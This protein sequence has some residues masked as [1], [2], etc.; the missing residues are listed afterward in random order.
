MSIKTKF[1]IS[2]IIMLVLPVFIMLLI[3][4][5]IF[6]IFASYMPGISIEISGMSET[7][8]N[9]VMQKYAILW[10]IILIGVVAICCV[11][12]TTYLS[13]TILSPLRQ[14]IDAMEHI[15]K[16]DLDYEFTCSADKEIR[17]VYDSLDRLRISLKNSVSSELRR[18]K[19]YRRLI[20]NI[21][22]DLRTPITSIK[23]YVEGI[24]DGVANTPEKTEKYLDTIL[25]KAN[26]LEK[27]VD[28]LSVYSRLDFENESYNMQIHDLNRFVTE[29][30]G[31]YSID[32]RNG[33]VELEIGEALDKGDT[34]YA[35]FDREKLR[36][37]IVNVVGNA[38]KYKKPGAQGS[39]K[40][41]ITHEDNG[42]I[43]S[44]ADNGIGISK[45]EESKVFET[46]YRSDP[47][48]NLDAQGNGLG[49]SIADRIVRE[50]GGKIWMRS[51]EKD[52]G[53]TVYIFL[54]NRILKRG[55]TCEY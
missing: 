35:K 15:A 37:V 14:M 42:V 43:L 45:E 11:G 8:T 1:F 54:P 2:S 55:R 23:G 21:S 22:H 33:N 17:E 26:V 41:D 39:L 51:N 25:L 5:F 7:Y 10:I 52:G 40:V 36:R 34:V 24:K 13:R 46:F 12:I 53:V 48:R 3:T 19:E 4:A 44:F 28:N 9:P 31:E 38:I 50:H 16:G 32:L 49:L 6:V 20:A 29:L 18:E 27:M 30:L 47:A